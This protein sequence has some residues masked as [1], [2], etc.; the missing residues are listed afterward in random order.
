MG[1]ADSHHHHHHRIPS[2]DGVL[3]RNHPF[4]LKNVLKNSLPK[5]DKLKQML[6]KL[7]FLVIDQSSHV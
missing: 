7:E 1:V 6:S 5:I 3:Y 2:I 4:N